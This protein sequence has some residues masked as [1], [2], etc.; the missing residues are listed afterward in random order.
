MLSE[1]YVSRVQKKPQQ[2][3]H[4]YLYKTWAFEGELVKFTVSCMQMNFSLF[5][6]CEN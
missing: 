4:M 5:T 6:K 2:V 1:L 3:T